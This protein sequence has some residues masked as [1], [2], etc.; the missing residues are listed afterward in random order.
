MGKRDTYTYRSM[1][2]EKRLINHAKL[3]SGAPRRGQSDDGRPNRIREEKPQVWTEIGLRLRNRQGTEGGHLRTI[4]GLRERRRRLRCSFRV[5][6]VPAATD[7]QVG[8]GAQFTPRPRRRRGHRKTGEN[9]APPTSRVTRPRFRE[10]RRTFPE[11]PCSA[12]ARRYIFPAKDG[13]C[14]CV[15]G[16]VRTGNALRECSRSANCVRMPFTWFAIILVWT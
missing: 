8:S 5:A 13:G 12:R 16:V 15:C 1:T 6:P 2:G 14:V 11:F 4:R 3:A 7:H 10:S 9:S